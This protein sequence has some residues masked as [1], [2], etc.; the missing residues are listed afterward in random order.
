MLWF[1]VVHCVGEVGIYEDEDYA[2]W[3]IEIKVKF[4]EAM[5]LALLTSTRQSGGVSPIIPQLLLPI[6]SY[7]LT[8]GFALLLGTST[9]NNDVPPQSRRSGQ[10][11]LF[12][13]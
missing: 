10:S 9:G 2:Q 8:M 13:G 7:L 6:S 12:G 5:P 11:S 4:S 3:G 1:V